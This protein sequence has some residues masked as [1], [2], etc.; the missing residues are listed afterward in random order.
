MSKLIVLQWLQLKGVVVCS[1]ICI[2]GVSLFL[3]DLFNFGVYC[4]DN[5]DYVEENCK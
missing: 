2:G 3:Y 1:F 4:G 5:L